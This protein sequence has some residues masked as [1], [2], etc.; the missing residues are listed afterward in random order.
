[1]ADEKKMGP[2]ESSEEEQQE[3]KTRVRVIVAEREGGHRG[4]WSAGRLFPAGE[5]EAELT[6]KEIDGLAKRPGVLVTDLNSGRQL[7]GSVSG[8]SFRESLTVDEKRALERYRMEKSADPSLA[9]RMMA[10]SAPAPSHSKRPAR[11]SGELGQTF[12]GKPGEGKPVPED[13]RSAL[14][15]ISSKDD[16]HGGEHP[17]TEAQKLADERSGKKK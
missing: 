4:W 14:T 1:M 15:G 11:P 6:D 10:D 5:T 8:P 16:H 9:E 2:Q 17:K 12:E 13:Q 3:R 7:K